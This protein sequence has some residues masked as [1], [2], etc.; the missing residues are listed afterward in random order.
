MTDGR[1]DDVQMNHQFVEGMSR[2]SS[3]SRASEDLFLVAAAG[4]GV[5]TLTIKQTDLS[6]DRFTPLGFND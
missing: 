4:F 6:M 2:T 3:V 1:T 5:A